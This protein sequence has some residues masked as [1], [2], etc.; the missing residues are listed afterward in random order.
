MSDLD[1]GG[2]RGPHRLPGGLNA[3]LSER[4]ELVD[5]QGLT[6]P[7]QAKFV[8]HDGSSAPVITDGPFPEGKELLAGYR[9]STSSRSSGRSR[10]PP[11]AQPRP[12]PAARRSASGSRCAR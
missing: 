11:R 10:S 3:E 8:V 9:M 6:A 7:E 2:D 12:A 5:A 4:G 1:A